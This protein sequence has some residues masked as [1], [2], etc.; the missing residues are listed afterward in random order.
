MPESL[1]QALPLLEQAIAIEPD[2]AAAHAAIAVCHHGQ[3]QRGGRDEAVKRAALHHARLAI[4]TGG[5]DPT[6]L[7]AAAFVVGSEDRDYSAAFDAFDRA[8]ALSPSS[9]LA[10]SFASMIHA[11]AG[12]ASTAVECAEQA[13]RLSPFDS[14]LHIPY[15]GLA[16]AH[17]F[18]GRFEE[19]ALAA[20][21]SM[22][23]NPRF[24]PPC[25]TRIAA[26]VNLGRREE[27][28]ASV[29]RLLELWP[30]F[31][32]SGYVAA[33]FTSP[34]RLAMYADVLRRAGLPEA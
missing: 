21:R 28:R 30:D 26:L 34:E 10:L 20:S 11:W 1:D 19:A 3:Y 22:Q 32:I 12:D 25:V 14:M 31:T 33:N 23:A 16:Y 24:S 27:A 18:A 4:A 7:A 5:D 2:Y 8:L 29:Q 13:L 9:F 17:L 6:A 15:N